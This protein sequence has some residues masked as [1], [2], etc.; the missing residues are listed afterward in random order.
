[1]HAILTFD[2]YLGGGKKGS[3]ARRKGCKLIC[4]VCKSESPSIKTLT[5]HY[6]SKH[7]KLTF[8]P[9]DYGFEP[10]EKK[11]KP[12]DKKKEAKTTKKYPTTE[13][14][15]AALTEFYKKNA[16]EK[17]DNIEKICT[18]YEGKWETLE[19][20]LSKKFS[21]EVNFISMCP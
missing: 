3:Q 1:M 16:P 9:K 11:Q 4:K 17:L 19:N 18:K 5:I 14:I 6:A 10:E 8:D 15:K 13:K 2:H 12:Q 20:A 7:S 21:T